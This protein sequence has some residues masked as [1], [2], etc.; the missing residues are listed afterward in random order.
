[1]K[2]LKYLLIVML[3]LNIIISV[4]LSRQYTKIR[5]ELAN[6]SVQ[7]RETQFTKSTGTINYINNGNLLLSKYEGNMTTTQISKM[8]SEFMTNTVPEIAFETKNM[9]EQNALKK[10]YSD[11]GMRKLTGINEQNI[12]EFYSLVDR[13][14]ALEETNLEF[15]SAEYDPNSIMVNGSS[16]VSGVL[17]IKYKN[18]SNT[19]DCYITVSFTS[20]Y[21]KFVSYN[22][23]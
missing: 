10:Y 11:N 2:N 18:V 4:I 5:D 17:K 19:L 23:D 3:I 12:N 21:I 9:Q 8:I 14:K 22:A 15:E 6:I 16:S 13:I 20:E 1:M 7:N